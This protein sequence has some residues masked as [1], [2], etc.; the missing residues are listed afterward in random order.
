VRPSRRT[1]A[2]RR[3]AHPRSNL[4]T[5]A[6]VPL[7]RRVCRCRAHARFCWVTTETTSVPMGTPGAREPK[8][9]ALRGAAYISRAA[10]ST[11]YTTLPGPGSPT[12]TAP[13]RD[14]TDVRGSGSRT[15]G[16]V[17]QPGPSQAAQAAGTGAVLPRRRDWKA[18]E[19]SAPVPA[20]ATVF[21]LPRERTVPIRPGGGRASRVVLA[22]IRAQTP[23]GVLLT[24]M[25][26]PG[27]Q[28]IGS[29][30]PPSATLNDSL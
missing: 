7:V 6:P 2:C 28:E 5:A 16:A 1:G 4:V 22:S 3:A 17:S 25:L 9:H 11:T 20:T 29:E 23:L 13:G 26:A 19:N 21:G 14:T 15:R 24:E 10:N 12:S 18:P 30:N 27:T 8:R